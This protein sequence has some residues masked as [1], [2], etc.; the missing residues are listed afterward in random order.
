MFERLHLFKCGRIV[1]KPD[2]DGDGLYTRIDAIAFGEFLWMLP[3]RLLARAG[4]A[5]TGRQGAGVTC[6]T[7]HGLEWH[8]ATG[9]LWL[10]VVAVIL[11]TTGW[12]RKTK[13][14]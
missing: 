14:D 9:L 3:A 5:G 10:F 7:G 6:H 4:R 13:A 11:Q 1:F 12:Q 2:W 8:I